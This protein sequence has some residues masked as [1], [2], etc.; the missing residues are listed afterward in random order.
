MNKSIIKNLL[1]VFTLT[2]TSCSY[3]PV[4]LKKDYGFELNKID[5]LGEKDVNRIIDDRLK[6]IKKSKDNKK[7]SFDLKINS[8]KQKNII[9]KNSQGDPLKFELVLLT[10]FEIIKDN[11]ILLNREIEK[12]Y[13][14][15]NVSDKF[16]LEQNE[17]IIINNL[18][19]KISEVIISLILNI[20]DS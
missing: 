7:N 16:K 18:A 11:K 14:Y 6:L 4:F 20:N 17:K 8:N 5:L 3:E 1:I 19:E 10:S 13:I 2:L 15:N 12:K 9:S